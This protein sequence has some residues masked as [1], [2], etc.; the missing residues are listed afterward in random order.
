MSMNF[1]LLQ[2]LNFPA[3]AEHRWNSS[4]TTARERFL[5]HGQDEIAEL[6]SRV[7]I[8]PGV[9]GPRAIAFCA[10]EAGSGAT[11]VCRRAAQ[12][13]ARITAQ[14]VCVVDSNGPHSYPWTRDRHA[15]ERYATLSP[16]AEPHLFVRQM[17]TRQLWL[18]PAGRAEGS[19]D[20][21]QLA[22]I[23]RVIEQLKIAFDFV[24][25]DSPP[26]SSGPAAAL[27]GKACDGLVLLV[28]ANSTGRPA[29][30]HAA[31]LLRSANVNLLGAVLNHGDSSL[32]TNVWG[33][34]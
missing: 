34:R 28:K 10:V 30:E 29:V 26:V 1:E 16:V 12:L 22:E 8:R 27:F 33:K 24:L 23:E 18:F 7:F 17:E 9:A 5:P 25:V 20:Q 4:T 19:A 32:P 2:R 31:N 15:G 3:D 14:S 11:F 13:L 6:V 21:P